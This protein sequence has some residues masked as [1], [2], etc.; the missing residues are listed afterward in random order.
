MGGEAQGPGGRLR[1][2][3]ANT[4]QQATIFIVYLTL[5]KKTI[6]NGLT[7]STEIPIFAVISETDI[8][9]EVGCRKK[10]YFFNIFCAMFAGV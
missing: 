6:S 10:Q 9:A 2:G 8:L 3:G 4:G 1:R 7:Q 5:L